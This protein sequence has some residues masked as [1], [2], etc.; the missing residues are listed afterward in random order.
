MCVPEAMSVLHMC[1]YQQKLE[2][3]RGSSE[4]GVT[5][6]HEL[7]EVR[8][9]LLSFLSSTINSLFTPGT[10]LASELC[11]C[12]GQRVLRFQQMSPWASPPPISRDTITG[13]E[14]CL[15]SA[16]LGT[17]EASSRGDKAVL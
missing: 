9:C 11:P 1:S 15:H 2:E 12:C 4:A 7:S 16:A 17:R 10:L 3:P 5:G 14:A 8:T 13:L 6:R